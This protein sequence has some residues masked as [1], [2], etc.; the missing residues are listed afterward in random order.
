MSKNIKT[1]PTF[2]QLSRAP[3][4]RDDIIVVRV[5]QPDPSGA[6]Y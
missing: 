3:G 1:S 2:S 6:R 5:N 4:W